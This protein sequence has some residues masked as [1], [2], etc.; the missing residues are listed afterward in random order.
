VAGAGLGWLV[1]YLF[2]PRSGTRRRKVGWDWTMGRVRRALRR[3]ER[4]ERYA[5]STASGKAQAVLHR[6]EAPKQ[7]PDDVTLAH[8]VESIV[9]RDP[10][11]PKGQISVNAEDG[12]VYL[13]GE[14]PSQSMLDEL[15]AK[16]REVRG[17]RGVQSLLHL[18]GEPA[19]MHE[20]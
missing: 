14:V 13:R 17:V 5:S 3:G 16:T 10:E 9:F 2:D 20:S 12:V 6:H 11:V 4:L 18:P 19:P 8:K 1:G 15:V 7:Q